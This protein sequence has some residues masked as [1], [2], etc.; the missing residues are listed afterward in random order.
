M[1]T[2]G[3]RRYDDRQV[4]DVR[5]RKRAASG[6]ALAALALVLTSTGMIPWA[7]LVPG[8]LAAVSPDTDSIIAVSHNEASGE[9]GLIIEPIYD[10]APVALRQQ[11]AED[12]TAG[13]TGANG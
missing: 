13:A 9:S 10:R 11:D 7:G 5:S 2:R 6:R 12:A 1:E 4:N 8:E 3:M